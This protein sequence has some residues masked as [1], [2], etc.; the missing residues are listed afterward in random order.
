METFTTLFSRTPKFR[1]QEKHPN[2]EQ[3]SKGNTYRQPYVSPEIGQFQDGREH[4]CENHCQT[5]G[6][7]EGHIPQEPAIALLWIA[8][9]HTREKGVRVASA[10]RIIELL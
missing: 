2:K 5:R 4:G 3:K 10:P 6:C 1:T 8:F 9:V 7:A